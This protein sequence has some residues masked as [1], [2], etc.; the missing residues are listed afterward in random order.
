VLDH[1]A[2]IEKSE[3]HLDLPPLQKWAEEGFAVVQLL[4]PGKLE[5][6]GEFPLQKASNVLKECER[7]EFEK[8]VGLICK[9]NFVLPVPA[10]P[11]QLE[12]DNDNRSAKHNII[13]TRSQHISP[14]YLSI[15]KKPPTSP[16]SSKP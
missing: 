5:D 6:G 13:L 16:P 11:R 12:P 9:S 2:L 14:A 10:E 1:Y 8:G 7:C 4:V 15:L 3:E